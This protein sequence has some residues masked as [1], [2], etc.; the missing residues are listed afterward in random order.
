MC[1]CVG[2]AKKIDPAQ[3]YIRLEMNWKYK[4]MRTF[5]LNKTVK[6]QFVVALQFL[7]D[8]HGGGSLL[9]KCKVAVAVEWCSF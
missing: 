7:R 8:I 4:Y 5:L 3:Q 9:L 1:V 6:I 2:W